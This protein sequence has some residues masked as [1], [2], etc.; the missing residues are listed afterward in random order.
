MTGYLVG[1]P[2]PDPIW[3]ANLW[4]ELAGHA[5]EEPELVRDLYGAAAGRWVDEGRNRHYAIVPGG[6]DALADAW[7]HVG[8][9]MQHVHG[10]RELSDEP[11]SETPVQ[12][13]AAEE[14]DVDEL[15]ELAPLLGEHQARSP[16]FG[17]HRDEDPDEIRTEILDELD[18]PELANLVAE[19]DDRVVGN[20]VVVPVEQSSMHAGLGRPDGAAFLGFAVTR[21][22]VRG[23]GA[24]LALTEA[25]FRWARERGYEV[26]VTD[27]RAT[28]LLSSRFWPARGFR[29]MFL[30][31]YR[32]IP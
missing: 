12:V 14:R 24:G 30:R 29:S 16:V 26:M 19:I 2:R 22:D 11:R 32:S 31:L 7:F 18:K 1:A 9:G 21:P 17:G 28:N 4:V 27:W 15:V 25:S 5:V 10:V 13:G 6:D 23:S 3:G 8:F 20:F